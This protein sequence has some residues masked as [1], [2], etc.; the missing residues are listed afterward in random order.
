[1]LHAAVIQSPVFGGKLK[2]VD[3]RQGRRRQGRAQGRQAGRCGRGGRRQLVAGE[4]GRRGARSR[5][6]RR[7]Q[8]PGLE[9]QHRGVPAQR[10]CGQRRGR[11]PQGRRR[12][13][14]PGA[15]GQT[16]R[17]RVCGAVPRPRHAWSRR[18][19]PPTSPRDKVEIWA[20][21]Q[22]GEATLAAA[23][24]AAGVPPRN[25][26]VHKMH[27]RR[28]LRPARRDAGLR[29]AGGR[30]AKQV[31]QPVKVI[32][33]REEDTRHDFYRPVAMARMAAGLDATA[34]RSPGTCG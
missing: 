27:A 3:E 25:V 14:R 24:Q 9:R 22:N 18:T 4:E 26:V 11:R 23:A 5:L 19:A 31:E 33:T 34:C 6:G 21:T 8:R 16:R 12:R 29:V 15:G 20:P 28:R 2:S 7:R 10:A 32:W 1:M 17:G 13:G 30:I